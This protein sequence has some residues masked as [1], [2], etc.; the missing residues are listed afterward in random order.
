MSESI[1]THLK[2]TRV[3]EPPA[4][5]ARQARVTSK[6]AYE[7]L[8]AESVSDPETFWRRETRD[9]VFRTPW[10]TTME[11]SLPHAKWFAGATLNIN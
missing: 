6:E 11:W 4:D 1:T 10:T 9:L 3:F 8:Y 2:E 5:F 7:K